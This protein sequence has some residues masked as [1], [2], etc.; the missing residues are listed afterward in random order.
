M[1]AEAYD[2]YV[3][4]KKGLSVGGGM[5]NRAGVFDARGEAKFT[6]CAQKN[7]GGMGNRLDFTLYCVRPLALGGKKH[8]NFYCFLNISLQ[9]CVF[10]NL[11]HFG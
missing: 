6:N 8:F 4:V 5:P 11:T 7:R 10:K 9:I 1:C 3:I 2:E